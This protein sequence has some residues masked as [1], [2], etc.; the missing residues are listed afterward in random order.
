MSVLHTKLYEQEVLNYKI[1]LEI[2][3]Y[4]LPTIKEKR[5]YLKAFFRYLEEKKIFTLEEIQPKDIA[6]YYKT[7][8][9]K[10]NGNTG[11]LITQESVKGRMRIIQ[12][13]FSHLIEIQKLKKDPASAFIFSAENRTRERIIFTQEQ[14][15][16]LYGKTEDLQEKTILNLAYGCGMRVGELVRINKE[17][18]NLQENLVIVEKGKNN[19]RRIIPITEKVKEELQEFLKSQEKREKNQDEIEERDSPTLWRQKA[20]FINIENR[21]MRETSFVRIL[22]KLLQKT[23]FGKKST[24]QEL[25]K[26]GMHT[27]R[28]SIA[29]H[30]LE[31]GMKL[32]Q[33]QYFLGHDHIET[34]EIYTHINQQQLNDLEI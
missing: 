24:T 17:D 33:I 10:R 25:R 8:Q 3:G 26:I 15:R 16:E 21:R 23:E 6:E 20:V 29:T 14:M 22:K 12:K 34:T 28:H 13:Y 7:L 11:E 18:I 19:K 32:E 9:Q 30:L 27:L 2:L 4:S 31:N 5:L 1:H